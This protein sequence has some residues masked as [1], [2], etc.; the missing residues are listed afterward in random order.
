MDCFCKWQRAGQ[1]ALSFHAVASDSVW[2][3]RFYAAAYDAFFISP[4]GGDHWVKMRS[5]VAP[6][7]AFASTAS[8]RLYGAINGKVIRSDNRG[9]TW[10][11]TA[12]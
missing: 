2:P 10:E 9:V 12:E 4:D 7:T 1:V 8:G 11:Y 3:A 6:V 5:P